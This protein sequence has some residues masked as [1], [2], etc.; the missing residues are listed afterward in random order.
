MS[1]IDLP[2]Y[3]WAKSVKRLRGAAIRKSRIHPT[4]KVE[5]GSQFYDSVMERHSF[6][7]YDCDI[8]MADIGPFCS[9]ANQVAIGGG[10][11]PIEWVSTSP[12]F[13][14]GRDSVRKKFSEFARPA[15]LRTLIGAD[16]WIGFRAVL[17]QGVTV[18]PG[19]VIGAHSVVTNDVPPYAIVGGTP[20][21]LISYRFDDAIRARLVASRWW[22]LS[23]EVIEPMALWIRDPERFLREVEQCG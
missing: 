13:Y 10:R 5:P 1:F 22:E 2:R 12:V 15:V 20:A 21:R 19:A 8:I 14:E 11:H 6:C 9:I 4:S 23:D 18:G 17:M 7:G 16:V 3:L